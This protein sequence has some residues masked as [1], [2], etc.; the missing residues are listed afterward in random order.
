M[1][2]SVEI[3]YFI[4]GVNMG[5]AVE[6]AGTGRYEEFGGEIEWVQPSMGIVPNT[7][8]WAWQQWE[9]DFWELGAGVHDH[10][11]RQKKYGPME[12]MSPF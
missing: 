7:G 5:G 6:I 10:I 8:E 9:R 12:S 11:H 3:D 2:S 4:E 1:E